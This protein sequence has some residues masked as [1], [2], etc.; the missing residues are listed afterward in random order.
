MWNK[1][2]EEKGIDGWMKR[3]R[4]ATADGGED[5]LLTSTLII[6]IEKSRK[7]DRMTLKPQQHSTSILQS[8]T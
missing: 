3:G 4:I 6:Q 8:E 2:F 5:P 1:E 7:A